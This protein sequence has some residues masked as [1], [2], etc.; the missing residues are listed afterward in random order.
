MTKTTPT[1][2]IPPSL[3]STRLA[4]DFNHHPSLNPLADRVVH[5]ASTSPSRE[6]HCNTPCLSAMPSARCGGKHQHWEKSY[7]LSSVRVHTISRFRITNY[8]VHRAR[9]TSRLPHNFVIPVTFPPVACLAIHEASP[10][11]SYEALMGR[12]LGNARH[13]KLATR[14]RNANTECP[15]RCPREVSRWK[16]SDA[17]P[18]RFAFAW[19]LPALGFEP[20]RERSKQ[21]SGVAETQRKS[22]GSMARTPC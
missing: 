3:W 4:S 6:S 19:G 13:Q 2:S 12:I 7:V 9:H 14:E 22:R 21:R 5:D 17:C 20:P 1:H 11:A 16:G 15:I 8:C 10:L 18:I